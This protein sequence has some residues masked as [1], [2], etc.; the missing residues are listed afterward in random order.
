[1]RQV[2]KLDLLLK[3]LYR[4]RLEG[5]YPLTDICKENDLPIKTNPE[6]EKL[7]K[8]LQSAGYISSLH[9]ADE[10]FAQITPEGIAYAQRDSYTYKGQSLISIDYG[11]SKV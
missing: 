9:A 4:I 7:I 11:L 6:L 8:Q 1:M 2:E 10:C 5:Y 3:T